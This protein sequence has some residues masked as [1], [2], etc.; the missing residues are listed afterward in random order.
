[1]GDRSGSEA[2]GFPHLHCPLV[3]STAGPVPHLVGTKL[4]Q[5]VVGPGVEDLWA[6]WLAQLDGILAQQQDVGPLQLAAG[7]CLCSL[8]HHRK[9]AHCKQRVQTLRSPRGPS[10]GCGGAEAAP[11]PP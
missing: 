7:S 9:C 6:G 5:E 3:P 8:H 2:K 11:A 4:A 1:M 10:P